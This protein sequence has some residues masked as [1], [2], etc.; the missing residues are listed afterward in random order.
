MG[1]PKLQS[2]FGC[3]DTR[4][5]DSRGQ[6]E[7]EKMLTC[8]NMP[9]SSDRRRFQRDAVE[10]PGTRGVGRE[11]AYKTNDAVGVCSVSIVVGLL[12]LLLWGDPPAAH[13]RP[14]AA[15]LPASG[16]ECGPRATRAAARAAAGRRHPPT[17]RLGHTP[18]PSDQACAQIAP[19]AE[20][21]SVTSGQHARGQLRALHP[22]LKLGN[23]ACSSRT[24]GVRSRVAGAGSSM[25]PEEMAGAAGRH[26]RR[27]A[28]GMG[29]L[30]TR[31]IG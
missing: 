29:R 1:P 2:A 16:C 19:G 12:A 8:L 10:L 28:R 22:Q 11:G 18:G 27:T 15:P 25:P 30:A 31:R 4:R 6:I 21:N 14:A 7:L 13:L 17:R 3:G 5:A 23:K 20:S 9:K 24:D 26:R